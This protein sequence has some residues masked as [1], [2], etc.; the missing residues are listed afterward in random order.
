MSECLGQTT[1]VLVGKEI[2]A[3]GAARQCHFQEVHPFPPG[4]PEPLALC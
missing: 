1:S 2:Q 4:A 3:E